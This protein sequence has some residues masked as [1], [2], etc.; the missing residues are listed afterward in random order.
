LLQQRVA[1]RAQVVAHL[2]LGHT[3]MDAELP[4]KKP[5]TQRGTKRAFV[6]AALQTTDAPLKQILDTW[7][8]HNAVT[9]AD[10][11]KKTPSEYL[12][13]LTPEQDE[14]LN[15]AYYTQLRGAIGGMR[16]FWEWFNRNNPK[17]IAAKARL[18]QPTGKTRPVTYRDGRTGT[19]EY[20]HGPRGRRGRC[21]R[22]VWTGWSDG[23]G[24]ESRG[25]MLVHVLS[26]LT[27]PCL[28]LA[29]LSTGPWVSG[30]GAMPAETGRIGGHGP[31]RS[32]CAPR[33]PIN[34]DRIPRRPQT[35]AP[36]L[37]TTPSRPVHWRDAVAVDRQQQGCGQRG[38]DLLQQRVADRA[39]VVAHFVLAK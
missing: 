12:E 25:P 16:S 29:T 9:E 10:R 4:W 21:P 33:G 32:D 6:L 37:S 34:P 27:E 13:E 11:V 5:K 23:R 28:D 8:V 20:K 14:A 35:C 22:R 30:A 7:A 15:E 36:D 38:R 26:S 17:Q 3:K 39:Q 2:C 1:D 24:C 18:G 31:R 19:Y